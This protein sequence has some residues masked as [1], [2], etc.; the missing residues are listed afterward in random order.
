MHPDASDAR[1][2][3][4]HDAQFGSEPL[5][6]QFFPKSSYKALRICFSY[7]RNAVLQFFLIVLFSKRCSAYFR[8][9]KTPASLAQAKLDFIH[10]PPPISQ[11]DTQSMDLSNVAMF[12]C[13]SIPQHGP[14][15]A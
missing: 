13:V 14:L 10:A 12:L 2:F 6:S 11:Y 1:Q 3:C 15:P 4:I 9:G 5:K 8:F 7:E